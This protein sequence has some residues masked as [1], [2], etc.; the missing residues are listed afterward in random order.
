[1]QLFSFTANHTIFLTVLLI[2]L[3]SITF[4]AT[5]LIFGLVTPLF[6]IEYRNKETPIFNKFASQKYF[7]QTRLAD[8]IVW[9][10]INLTRHLKAE[11][12]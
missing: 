3:M 6:T 10:K 12:K 4:K 9:H 11:L 7:S 5:Y 2:I 1:M 8:I